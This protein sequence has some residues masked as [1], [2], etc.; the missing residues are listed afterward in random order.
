[1]L[2]DYLS[3][4]ISLDKFDICSKQWYEENNITLHLNKIVHRIDTL[5]K[6]VLI[7]DNAP[8]DYDKLILATGSHAVTPPIPGKEK[9]RVFS[10]KL[11]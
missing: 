5:N 1:M 10:L 6:K 11:Y 3:K 2:C 8:I 9:E 7:E 4:D